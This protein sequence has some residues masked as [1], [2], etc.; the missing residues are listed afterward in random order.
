[1]VRDK[2]K[3][4]WRYNFIPSSVAIP[5][6]SSMLSPFYCNFFSIPLSSSRNFLPSTH[7]V[8]II[9]FH[10]LIKFPQI[11]SIQP[12]YSKN[13]LPL[14]HHF[15]THFFRPVIVFPLFMSEA[16]N[17]VAEKFAFLLRAAATDLTAVLRG[18]LCF[19][20]VHP[21]KFRDSISN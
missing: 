5:Q 13:L 15:L 7:Y 20:S 2:Q 6:V 3:R 10:P 16:T 21:A 4:L 19:S 17:V 18:F 9:F 12:S 11:S 14:S 8:P 1:M